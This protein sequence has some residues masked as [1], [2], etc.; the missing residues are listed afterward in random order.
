M[1]DKGR[2]LLGKPRWEESPIQNLIENWPEK[3]FQNVIL[4]RIWEI[5]LGFVVWETWKEWNRQIFEGRK[6]KLV[7]VWTLIYTHIKETLGLKRWDS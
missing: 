7:E 5:L 2:T 3:A 4:N 1:W 6:R